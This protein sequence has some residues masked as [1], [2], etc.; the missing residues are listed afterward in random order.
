MTVAGLEVFEDYHKYYHSHI[1]NA[2]KDFVPALDA[3]LA[4]GTLANGER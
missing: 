1:G 2:D 4:S 3:P